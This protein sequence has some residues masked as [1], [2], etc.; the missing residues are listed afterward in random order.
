MRKHSISNI[1]AVTLMVVLG[2]WGILQF[3][4]PASAQIKRPG[5]DG[6]NNNFTGS[7]SCQKCHERFYQLWAPSHHGLAMQP[8][9]AELARDN[10]SAQTE[11][12]KI[13]YRRSFGRVY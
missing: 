12:I 9:T 2:A 8:F 3:D 6:S 4:S 11:A 7:Q 10:L 5:S 13:V 1:V